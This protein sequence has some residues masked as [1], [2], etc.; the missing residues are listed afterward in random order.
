MNGSF[1]DSSMVLV[2]FGFSVNK[3]PLLF[4][5]VLETLF[6]EISAGCPKKMFYADIRSAGVKRV[7]SR[8]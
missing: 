5:V 4:I 8:C 7:E 6:R 3:W 2:G 1:S